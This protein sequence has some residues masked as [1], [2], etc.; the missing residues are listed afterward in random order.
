MT[1]ER[2]RLIKSSSGSQSA[3]SAKSAAKKAAVL[4]FSILS[5]G[6][7]PARNRRDT[8]G[9]GPRRAR[10]SPT[11]RFTVKQIVRAGII[12][13]VLLLASAATPSQSADF[14]AFVDH[15][16]DGFARRHPSIA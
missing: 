1:P 12:G 9:R 7:L 2:R 8:L 10:S 4:V 3:K 14:A 5:V 11:I 15:Y 6:H 16:L 13:S